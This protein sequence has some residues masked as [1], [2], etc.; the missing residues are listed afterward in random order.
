MLRVL[1]RLALEPR[2]DEGP[3]ERPHERDQDEP[4]HELREGELPAQQQPQHQ[5]ELPHE[6]GG[7]ELEGQRGRRRGASGEQGARDG[8]RRVGARRGRGAEA[9][10]ASDGPDTLAAEPALD[11]GAWH[12]GLHDRRDREAQDERPP[13]LVR[14]QGGVG[15]PLGNLVDHVSHRGSEYTPRVSRKFC[16]FRG[17][18]RKRSTGIPFRSRPKGRRGRRD[19]GADPMGPASWSSMCCRWWVSPRR[20]RRVGPPAWPASRSTS[21]TPSRCPAPKRGGPPMTPID[22]RIEELRPGV[23]W[24]VLE[25]ELD[26]ANAYVVDSQLR[27]VEERRPRVLM[28]DLRGLSFLDSTGLARLLAAHRR[29]KRGGWRLVLIRGCSAVQRVLALSGLRERFEIVASPDV[30]CPRWL[31]TEPCC[32]PPPPR[33]RRSWRPRPG[34]RRPPRRSR[35]A[36]SRNSRSSR[37]LR[38]R[39]GFYDHPLRGAGGRCAAPAL[40]RPDLERVH[41]RPQQGRGGLERRRRPA[42]A[43]A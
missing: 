4:A 7:G 17:D 10:R 26:S 22:L 23:M 35:R 37:G 12:P 19:R 20:A 9:G 14:H 41:P 40:V 24:A 27:R 13:H 8:D 1:A 31:P 16:G 42:Q 25:G 39:Q 43:P 18:S 36:D 32:A 15:Q 5:A 2:R 6:V 11:A 21:R 29:A 33:S 3:Q 34:A 28:I 30:P 38:A